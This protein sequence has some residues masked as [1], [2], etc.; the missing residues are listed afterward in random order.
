LPVQT[1]RRRGGAPWKLA[2]GALGVV[3][4]D[5]GTS[6]LYALRESFHPAHGLALSQ[7]NVLGILSLVFWSLTLVVTL[8]Y[9]VFILRADHDGEGGITS[10]L[11]LL[12][13]RLKDAGRTRERTIVIFLGLFGAGLL[14]GDG[15]LT[16]AIS[17]LS[18][19]E[20]L[21]VATPAFKPYVVPITVAI[22]VAL[23]VAQRT[24]TGP[25]GA[26]FGPVTAIWFLTLA[27]LGVSW[28]V[29]RPDVLQAL[30]PTY[31][32][33]FFQRN[34]LHGFLS[35]GAVVLCITGAEAL[36]ADMGHF[37]RG[38]IRVAWFWLVFPALLLNYLGQGAL[39]LE[40][41]EAVV[42]NVFFA[43]APEWALYPLVAIATAATVIASQA[44]ISGA[45]SL[46]QQSVQLGFLPR[47]TILHTSRE[48]EGQIYV[49]RVN[50]F[51]MIGCIALVF[52]FKSSS[53][54]A[55]AYGI[56]VTATMAVTSVLFGWVAIRVWGWKI[57]TVFPLVALFLAVD[58]AYL[59]ANSVKI[60]DGGW[61]PVLI[62]LAFLA[63][64]TTWKRGREVLARR[65][66][67]LSGPLDA[68]FAQIE[69]DRPPR[70]KGTAVFMTLSRDIA[71][72]SLLHHYRH[73]KALHERVILLSI[74]TEHRPEV[75][76]SDRIRLTDLPH[77][78]VKAVAK[79]G[80]L[81]T[82]DVTELLLIAGRAGLKVEQG[83]V[84][85][86]LGRE[87]FVSG[88]KSGMAGWRRA[89]FMYLSRNARPATE[90]FGLPPDQVVEL[91]AQI[92][93]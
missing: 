91:G 77:G 58:L 87:T 8:K 62:A 54:L 14:Y 46:T 9:L 61:I 86:F 31:A 66:A 10:L 72:A 40:H 52:V 30:N 71:P 16:P 73:N 67:E 44:L 43:M 48:R 45:F 35:L 47:L 93:V 64:M 78:F 84:S 32:L 37:G 65:M 68:F 11:A 57:W 50:L 41:G 28:I 92:R 15:V 90:F 63:V 36:Y 42:S 1:R 6:P 85:F 20:G 4:G 70:V 18:A 12:M 33:T 27:A 88:G 2:L 34:G 51:L 79:Y 75:Q 53:G 25:I 29:K 22:L 82:P 59:G 39:V 3:F 56:A 19:V 24:G 74:S 17:V 21:E 80:Y 13:P 76:N 7:E 23:F 49:P 38:P 55:G 81:E 26:V 89:L 5:I 83:Q 69:R 60:L